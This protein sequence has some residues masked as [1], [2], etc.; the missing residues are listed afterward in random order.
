MTYTARRYSRTGEGPHSC[1]DVDSKRFPIL[2][3]NLERDRASALPN[4]WVCPHALGQELSEAHRAQ[5]DA[6]AA[7]ERQAKAEQIAADQIEEYGVSVEADERV[8]SYKG[9]TF[10][11]MLTAAALAGMEA[12][13]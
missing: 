5:M 11:E 4:M 7:T 10:R 8:S 3:H 9:G 6:D 13:R 2:A 12:A 1:P